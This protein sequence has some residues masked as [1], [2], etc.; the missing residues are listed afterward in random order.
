MS[1][2]E[3]IQFLVPNIYRRQVLLGMKKQRI[4]F[5]FLSNFIK[6][7]P[8]WRAVRPANSETFKQFA[9]M[10]ENNIIESLNAST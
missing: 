10:I 1:L 8:F 7:M 5:D 6:T 2:S 4:E 9:E 3:G